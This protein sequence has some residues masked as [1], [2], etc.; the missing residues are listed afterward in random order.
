M[1]FYEFVCENCNIIREE[2]ASIING[3]PTVKCNKCGNKM[4]QT[5]DCQVIFVGDNWPDK[6]VKDKDYHQRHIERDKDEETLHDR[7]VAQ[8]EAD[9]VLTARRKGRKASK[10]YR[11]HHQEIWERTSKNRHKGI[12]KDKP[13][14]KD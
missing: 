13:P 7:K 6:M 3:P 10:E 12:V 5:F 4:N 9:E 14:E 8:G 2:I 11:K 1:P